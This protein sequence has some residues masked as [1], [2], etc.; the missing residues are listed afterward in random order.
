MSCDPLVRISDPIKRV[1][2]WVGQEE[3][4]PNAISVAP[5]NVARLF[6]ILGFTLLVTRG[7]QSFSHSVE[8]VRG[9]RSSNG[10]THA[11]QSHACVQARLPPS[12]WATAESTPSCPIQWC[13]IANL[14][15]PGCAFEPS[16]RVFG[17]ASLSSHSHCRPPPMSNL[18]CTSLA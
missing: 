9:P 15:R 17:L 4:R 10:H 11:T 12:Q 14:Q 13:S 5:V 3:I 6:M 16:A 18:P 7:A 1:W 2:A 8:R